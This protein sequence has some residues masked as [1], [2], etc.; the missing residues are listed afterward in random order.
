MISCSPTRRGGAEGG[1]KGHVDF[2][3]VMREDGMGE[4]GV[5]V[6]GSRG[7][8]SAVAFAVACTVLEKHERRLCVTKG[9]EV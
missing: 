6:E 7:R 3:W 9:E 2:Y 4:G 5:V 1:C 8:A